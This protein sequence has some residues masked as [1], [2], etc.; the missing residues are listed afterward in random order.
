VEAEFAASTRVHEVS[1]VASRLEI[2]ISAVVLLVVASKAFAK[3]GGPPKLDMEYA[4]HASEKAVSAV[5]SVTTDIYQSCLDD[6]NDARVQLDKSWA[7]FLASDK[8]RC[9]HP[10]E[11][12]PGYV[13]WLTCLEMNMAVREMRRGRPAATSSNIHEC[14]VVRFREDGTI[15]SVNTAC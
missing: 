10:K 5:I 12:L 15:T 7:T 11:Y 14:P 9:I 3:D 13:E 4:C 6:E 1:S 2:G 8:A